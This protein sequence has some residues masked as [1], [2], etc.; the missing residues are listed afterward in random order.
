VFELSAHDN[1]N[2]STASPADFEQLIV[3]ENNNAT[4]K[5]SFN[6]L[7]YNSGI[8][9]NYKLLNLEFMDGVCFYLTPEIG[10]DKYYFKYHYE[11]FNFDY[12]D[13]RPAYNELFDKSYKT[14]TWGKHISLGFNLE[15]YEMYIFFLNMKYKWAEISS[16]KSGDE[17][18]IY[19]DGKKVSFKM[20]TFDVTLGGGI[21]FNL[22]P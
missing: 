16:L 2:G 17:I 22:F 15:F 1:S 20:K 5:I 11:V 4:K 8:A 3:D 18:M 12:T 7:Y 14:T 21:R 10:I 9:I 6:Y 19:N 13:T